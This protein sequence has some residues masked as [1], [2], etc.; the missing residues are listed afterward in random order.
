[1][2]FSKTLWE[3]VDLAKEET[4]KFFGVELEFL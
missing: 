4:F 2:D 1:M 3:D